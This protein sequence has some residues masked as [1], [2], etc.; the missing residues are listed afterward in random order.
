MPA[1]IN[2]DNGVASGS[3]GLKYSTDNTGTLALQTNGNT[4]MT[5]D[6]SQNILIARTSPAWAN[7]R[8][9]LDQT[10]NPAGLLSWYNGYPEVYA[11]GNS[12][13][14][15]FPY[16]PS[17]TQEVKVA[18]S[19]A[20]TVAGYLT[21]FVAYNGSTATTAY[22]GV[23]AGTTY[24]ANMVFGQRTG[25]Q[26]WQET[27][28]IDSSGRVTIPY[29][30]YFAAHVTSGSASYTSVAES[31]PL[32]AN[33]TAFNVGSHYNT[34]NYRFTAPIAGNY[35][36]TF[37][38]ITGTSNVISRPMFYINGSSGYTNG[39]QFGIS[40]GDSGSPQNCTSA[41][42]RLNAG[43]YVDVRSQAGRL[44][45]Y[46]GSHSSFTGILLS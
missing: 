43:D 33:S 8:F 6:S 34:T 39:L 38:G 23:T 1:I 5:V 4:A 36:F 16:A 35:L 45:Y 19:S 2:A 15:K 32:P 26:S 14:T 17:G 41:I 31:V 30:P 20:S 7:T 11:T 3:V 46:S 22:M 9:S 29:Q 44:Y 13:S 24:A 21:D 12:P 27:M 10:T 42:I 18:Q 37:S 25:V 40:G 28:R